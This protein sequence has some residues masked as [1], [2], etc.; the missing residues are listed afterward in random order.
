MRGGGSRGGGQRG[1][2]QATTPVGGVYKDTRRNIQGDEEFDDDEEWTQVIRNKPKSPPN[3][4]GS[5]SGPN[6]LNQPDTGRSYASAA[7]SS[8]DHQQPTDPTSTIRQ[9]TERPKK[10]KTPAPEGSM[11]DDLVIEIQTVNGEKFKGSVNVKE[12]KD[13]IFKGKL[14]LDVKLL[15]GIRF[16]FSTYP[17]VK[18]KLKE[19]IDVDALAYCEHFE[20]QRPYTFNGELKFDTLGCK[21]R[22]IRT[23]ANEFMEADT[24]PNIRWV[25]IEWVDYGLD[26][27]QILAWMDLFGER[28]GELSEDIHPNSD[29][30][31]DFLCTGT[32]SIKMRL[33]K[34]IPQLLPMWGKRIRVYHRGVQKLC[35]NCYGPHTRRNCRSEK[36][37]WTQYVLKFM[38]KH[39]EIPSDLYGRWWKVINDEYGEIVQTN[40][41]PI[42]ANNDQYSYLDRQDDCSGGCQTELTKTNQNE[43]Q[44]TTKPQTEV[45]QKLYQLSTEEENNLSVY[46]EL[47]MSLNEARE[48]YKKEIEVAQM[49]R[50]IRDNT[51]LKERGSVEASR[52]TIIGPTTSA[53]GAGRGGLSFN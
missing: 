19:Q 23:S 1:K 4:S 18:F 17:V 35:N 16:G 33:N 31:P 39:P 24:D 9:P 37:P 25:K 53:R 30:E 13:E 47:G 15:H 22:G 10:F 20:F 3:Q 48:Q 5:G 44:P 27:Q 40:E 43:S 12:A 45:G 34:D 14:G 36:V 21:I 46:L 42:A 50:R 41:E 51:R 28:A 2:R 6:Q 29:S 11:R 7:A 32:Y 49:R 52:S 8:T 26:E 38:E